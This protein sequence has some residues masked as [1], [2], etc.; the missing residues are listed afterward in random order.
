MQ[1]V[2]ADKMSGAATLGDGSGTLG[3]TSGGGNIT[4]Y[5]Q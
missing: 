5:V 3:V 4:F 1:N 2:A